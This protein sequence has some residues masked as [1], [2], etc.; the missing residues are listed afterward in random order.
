MT[1]TLF[2]ALLMQHLAPHQQAQFQTPVQTLAAVGRGIGPFLGTLIIARGDEYKRGLGPPL[3]LLM[4]FLSVTLSIL[5]PT[6]WC[7]YF[8]DPPKPRPPMW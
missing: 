3:M 1:N 2:N 7:G 6:L 5:V 8:Y 4:A